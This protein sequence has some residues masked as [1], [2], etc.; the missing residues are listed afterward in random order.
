MF[1]NMY[2]FCAQ[3]YQQVD[4]NISTFHRKY[5]ENN[6][7]TRRK[8]TVILVGYQK[9]LQGVFL[10]CCLHFAWNIGNRCP[11][12]LDTIRLSKTINNSHFSGNVVFDFI[13]PIISAVERDAVS[14]ED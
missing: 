12:S 1:K 14:V 9:H 7:F 4:E 2:V 6:K 11:I 5:K 10:F 3:I 13:L 8:T